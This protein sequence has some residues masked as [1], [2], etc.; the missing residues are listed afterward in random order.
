V[1]TS[2]ITTFC[3]A[4][5]FVPIELNFELY[6]YILASSLRG[7]NIIESGFDWNDYILY[8]IPGHS[9]Y[10]VLRSL[11]TAYFYACDLCLLNILPNFFSLFLPP[12]DW[13]ALISVLPKASLQIDL[14]SCC[15]ADRLHSSN[16]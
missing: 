3:I 11:I 16:V 7:I 6:I 4:W 2:R 13:P 1:L 8:F 12:R 10:S 5:G 9:I 14:I 15:T